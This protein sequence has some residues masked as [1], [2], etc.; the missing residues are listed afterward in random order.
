MVFFPRKASASDSVIERV[1]P[2][3]SVGSA[4]R[5][6]QRPAAGFH[7]GRRRAHR[8]SEP[9]FSL[10]STNFSTSEKIATTLTGFAIC[11]PAAASV[12][13]REAAARRPGGTPAQGARHA[14]EDAHHSVCSRRDIPPEVIRVC[15]SSRHEDRARRNAPCSLCGGE[16][17][18]QSFMGGSQQPAKQPGFRRAPKGS[19]RRGPLGRGLGRRSPGHTSDSR[20]FLAATEPFMTRIFLQIRRAR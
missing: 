12:G 11:R 17:G 6:H 15:V 1:L 8:N 4:Q 2:R 3:G 14:A 19:H 16:G 20:I 13:R 5:R 9:I 7:G 18:D 10:S